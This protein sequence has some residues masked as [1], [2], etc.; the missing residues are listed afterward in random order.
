[1]RRRFTSTVLTASISMALVADAAAETGNSVQVTRNDAAQ[2]VDVNIDG[3]PFTSYMWPLVAKKPVLYPL[4]TPKGTM[5]TRGYPPRPG[6]PTDHPHHIGFWLNYGDVNGVDFWGNSEDLKPEERTKKGTIVHKAVKSASSGATRGE[7]EV[8]SDWVGPTGTVMLQ[9]TT[10]YVFRAP[11]GERVIDRIT[12]L[13]A[14]ADR[15]V[16]AD[17]KEG[18]LGIRVARELQHPTKQEQTFTDASGN[19]ET[20]KASGPST[21]VYISSEGKRGDDVWGTAARWVMLQGKIGGEDITLAIL[22]HPSNPA[23]PTHWHARGYGLFAVN[24][25]G[26]K[27][28]RKGAQTLN[29][30]LEPGASLTFRHRVVILSAAVTMEQMDTRFQEFAKPLKP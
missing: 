2:R 12:T 16:F 23:H 29:Y 5:V 3:Q 11:A 30:A 14:Q 19:K 4:R 21:G 13:R 10:R 25:F 20:V 24:P 17:T 9:E 27:D 18:M 6:E 8:Q 1:M 26:V 7:L 22:D 15:I 28:F